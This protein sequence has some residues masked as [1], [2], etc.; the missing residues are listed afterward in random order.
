MMKFLQCVTVEGFGLW[1]ANGA[2]GA[3]DGEQRLA[4][5]SRS[6]TPVAAPQTE[7]GRL[8][9][10]CGC[11]L[12]TSARICG[13]ERASAKGNRATGSPWS[14]ANRALVP[15]ESKWQSK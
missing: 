2:S 14:E 15:E 6:A 1:S 5:R 3:E 10:L 7:A 9:A 4:N 12:G 13:V 8:A 11:P